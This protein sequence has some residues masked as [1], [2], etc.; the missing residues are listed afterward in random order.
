MQNKLKEIGL[1]NDAK[2]VSLFSLRIASFFD[3]LHARAV[4]V[5]L[6][7]RGRGR[8][9]Q[10]RKARREQRKRAASLV[11][12]T[13][14]PSPTRSVDRVQQRPA[15]RISVCDDIRTSFTIACATPCAPTETIQLPQTAAHRH[16]LPRSEQRRRAFFATHRVARVCSRVQGQLFQRVVF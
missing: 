4:R 5:A 6:V 8:C 11:E 14:A 9:S 15:A 1:Q 16:S 10:R 13:K 7:R 12:E 3:F 2:L